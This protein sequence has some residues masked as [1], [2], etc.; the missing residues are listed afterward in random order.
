MQS[1]EL[2]SLTSQRREWSR[3]WERWVPC[4]WAN[5]G[6][7]VNWPTQLKKLSRRTTAR[8]AWTNSSRMKM[9]KT[10]YH[11]KQW[12]L[13]SFTDKE[14]RVA[15]PIT[16]SSVSFYLKTIWKKKKNK[17]IRKLTLLFR[18]I[19]LF[20]I[21]DSSNSILNWGNSLKICQVKVVCSSGTHL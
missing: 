17:E 9:R 20:Q 13:T 10:R 16:E 7:E 12:S 3:W 2:W 14:S 1:R 11:L 5:W 15:T 8:I 4:L 6:V 19:W 18:M 21:L